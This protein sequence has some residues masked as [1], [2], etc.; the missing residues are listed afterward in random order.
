ML[1]FSA[2]PPMTLS[3]DRQ[4]IY[5][6]SDG[7]PMADNTEQFKWIVL[8]KENL[9]CLFAEN[10]QVFVA[11]D[12]LWYP[13]EGQ[14]QIRVAPDVFVA[15]GRPKGKRGS[16]RQWEEDNLPPQVVFEILSPSNRAK[17]M[18]LKLQ[19]YDRY[20]VSEY[21]IYDPQNNEL[22][23]LHRQ[24]N[25]LTLIQNLSTWTSPLLGI[26]FELMPETLQVY[27]PD[28]R[29]FLTTVELNQEMTRE[30]QRGDRLAAKLQALGIDP[31]TI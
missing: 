5:P 20:G 1:T 27:Y 22:T 26:K 31:D 10:P 17:E 11:G 9:E 30:K 21:Y 6:E 29:R 2:E 14:P 13:V 15:L 7:Q 19:F 12:L 28:G 25:Q 16:Y 3:L 24:D 8:L 4:L 23:G 18:I